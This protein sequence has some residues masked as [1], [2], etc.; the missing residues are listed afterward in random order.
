MLPIWSRVPLRPGTGSLR[1]E[2]GPTSHPYVADPDSL[3]QATVSTDSS[4]RAAMQP[5]STNKRMQ[6]SNTR[7]P[8]GTAFSKQHVLEGS[9]Q[10]AVSRHCRASQPCRQPFLTTASPDSVLQATVSRQPVR[11][12]FSGSMFKHTYPSNRLSKQFQAAVCSQC[13][14]GLPSRRTSAKQ[15]CPSKRLQTAFSKQQVLQTAL[16]EQPCPGHPRHA[17]ICRNASS[18]ALLG[19][20]VGTAFSKQHVPEDSLQAAVF[21][22]C[23][24]SQPCRQPFL[25]SMPIQ[26]TASPSS[27]LQA[28]VSKQPV[29]ADFAD[30]FLKQPFQAGVAKHI[31][32]SKSSQLPPS[33]RDK[34]T[35]YKQPSAES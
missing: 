24:A 35:L 25:P 5:P 8:V 29:R 6:K 23:R 32:P 1:D 27:V 11:A 22:H 13:F 21:R 30:N 17:D 14:C 19:Q 20:P 10:A 9:L 2:S 3:L 7:Q 28:T 26:A 34:A 18:K 33:N 12:A 15:A 31:S 4:V 16:S